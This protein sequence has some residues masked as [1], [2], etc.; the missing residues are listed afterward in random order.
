MC[1][2]FSTVAKIEQCKRHGVLSYQFIIF[3]TVDRSDQLFQG[4][5]ILGYC[6]VGKE[7]IGAVLRTRY[8]E[9][10]DM[11]WEEMRH[12]IGVVEW[13]QGLPVQTRK[14]IRGTLWSL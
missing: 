4:R 12:G 3:H 14:R 6:C 8:V 10:H 7:E 1:S 2:I 13:F 5:L 11:R 9:I